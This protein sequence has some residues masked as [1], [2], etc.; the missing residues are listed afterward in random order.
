MAFFD[1]LLVGLWAKL[2]VDLLGGKGGWALHRLESQL[3]LLLSIAVCH[4][5][6]GK[7]LLDSGGNVLPYL[8]IRLLLLL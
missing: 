1:R 8:I 7:W 4:Y 2:L 5:S 3:L 6:G